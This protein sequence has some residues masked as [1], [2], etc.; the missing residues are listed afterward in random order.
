MNHQLDYQP[1]F[2]DLL[3]DYIVRANLSVDRLSKRA[4]VPK[5]TIMNWRKGIVQRPRDWRGVVRVASAL[6]LSETD[7]DALLKAAHHLPIQGLLASSLVE[8]DRM[9]LDFWI[10]QRAKE[11][12][13]TEQ[14]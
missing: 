12:K 9:L 2:A 4:D 11:Q 1:D 10:S 14:A 5:P 13:R 7:A 8:E 3:D 6:Q